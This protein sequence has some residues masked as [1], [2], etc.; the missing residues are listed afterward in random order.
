MLCKCTGGIEMESKTKSKLTS[1]KIDELVKKA[2][3]SS[4]NAEEMEELTEGCFNT[5]YRITLSNGLKT[6]LKVSPPKDVLVMR[7]E[8]NIMEAEVYVLDK[9]R[10][11]G[12]MPV[13][14]V[15]Y[16]DKSGEIISS[17]YFFMEYIDGVPLNRIHS[18]LSPQQQKEISEELGVLLKRIHSIESSYFGYI[19]QE[20]R[21]F[22]TWEEAFLYMIKELLEDAKEANVILP[23][24]YDKLYNVIYEKREVL[25]AVK[26]SS[27]LHKDLWQGN[28]FVDP[29]TTKITGIVDCERALYGDVLLDLVCSFLLNDE[30]FM[31]SYMERIALERDEEIRVVLYRIY[32]FL[33]MHIECFYRHYEDKNAFSWV[34]PEL[35]KALDELTK[36]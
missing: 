6:V 15:Y 12:D 16:Y 34:M 5:A 11:L 30:A 28:I 31:K 8:K 18:E 13:P 25:K 2:F 32:L 19:S 33:I 20:D 27:L 23:Y 26:V 22:P 9:T 10:E 17:E 7:Y 4:I 1:D 35:E 21:R 29:K 36:L 3:G 14:K 24:D